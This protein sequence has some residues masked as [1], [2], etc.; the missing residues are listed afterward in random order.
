MSS[1]LTERRDVDPNM[2]ISPGGG[3]VHLLYNCL[4]LIDK[5]DRKLSNNRQLVGS[6]LN[7]AY[8]RIKSSRSQKK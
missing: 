8:I 2:I 6:F 3:I 5:I 7:T 4:L 1:K